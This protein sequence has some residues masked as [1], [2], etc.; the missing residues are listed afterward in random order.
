MAFPAS[1]IIPSDAYS[2]A[3]RIALA[4]KAMADLWIVKLTGNV[5]ADEVWSLYREAWYSYT[6]L[7]EIAA[8][9]GIVEYAIAQESDPTL[10]VVAEFLAMLAAI[11][12]ARSWIYTAIPRDPN[13]YTL[14]HT[15]MV[16][17]TRVPAVWPPGAESTGP[18]IPLLQAVSASIA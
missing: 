5:D 3:K 16:D 13:G 17:G 14:T 1:N 9:P 2:E 12:A 15:T 8:V 11:N 18:L 4:I 7:Q 10:D 6:R